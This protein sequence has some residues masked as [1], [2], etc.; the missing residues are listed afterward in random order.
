MVELN[1]NQVDKSPFAAALESAFDDTGLF[2]RKE[3][4]KFL[5]VKEVSIS[6]W[7]NDRNLPRPSHLSTMLLTLE[8]SSDVKEAPLE[9]FKAMAARPATEVSPHGKRMLPT[10]MEYAKRP[11]FSALSSALAK[12]SPDEQGELLSGIYAEGVEKPDAEAVRQKAEAFLRNKSITQA[13]YSASAV[14]M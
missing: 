6:D 12:L 8:G 2:T 13:N 5:G 9:A 1:I 3:W 7:V 4:A 10:V 14:G 11:V